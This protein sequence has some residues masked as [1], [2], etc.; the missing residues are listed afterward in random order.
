[1]NRFVHLPRFSYNL[2]KGL[3]GLFLFLLGELISQAQNSSPYD[4]H[5]V[6]YRLA[7]KSFVY[8]DSASMK[9]IS[10]K[11]WDELGWF[12]TKT[13][14]AAAK[15]KEKWGIINQ[16]EEFIIQPEW[17]MADVIYGMIY[18]KGKNKLSIR[19]QR[20]EEVI[21]AELE[22]SSM[23]KPAQIILYLLSK[24]KRMR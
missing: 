8:V 4:T 17:D 19:N 7:N 6:P 24:V 15:K 1:M 11:E 21:P 12:D 18:L 22:I 3:L 2:L 23:G 16:N 13:G 20:L 10:G 5:R 9:P 14:F